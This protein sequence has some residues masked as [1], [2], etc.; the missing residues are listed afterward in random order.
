MAEGPGYEVRF[1]ETSAGTASGRHLQLTWKAWL[2]DDGPVYWEFRRLLYQLLPKQKAPILVSKW[3]QRYGPQL[4]SV[5]QS[6]GLDMDSEVTSSR[7]ATA[8]HADTSQRFVRQEFSISTLGVIAFLLFFAMSRHT[9]VDRE[10][11]FA[12]LAAVLR[13]SATVHQLHPDTWETSMGLGL[14]AGRCQAK[15]QPNRRHCT[16]LE[17]ALDLCKPGV[18]QDP[19]GALCAGMV[20]M[21]SSS[22]LCE[23]CRLSL[24]SLIGHL[25]ADINLRL[26]GLFVEKD[27]LHIPL[28]R[29]PARRL[30]VDEDFKH[31]CS[32]ALVQG[33]RTHSGA[34][35]ARVTGMVASSSARQWECEHLRAYQAAGWKTFRSST[36]VC[37]AEDATRLGQ[38]PQ[39]TV[40]YIAWSGSADRAMY[41]PVQAPT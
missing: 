39:E 10:G 13:S 17:R 26:P 11:G 14:A 15:A 34:Q 7:R 23:A 24:T 29:G 41:L 22:A 9:K 18:G 30:R 6:V 2:Y 8:A 19:W 25:A 21:M 27:V 38:P 1:L 12:A 4:A 3:L 33:K 40:V 36:V 16:H 32:V 31:A 5:F 28:M 37:L 20:W 35:V